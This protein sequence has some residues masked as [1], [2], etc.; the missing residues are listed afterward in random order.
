MFIDTD[1][2]CNLRNV[3]TLLNDLSPNKYLD[4]GLELKVKKTDIETFESDNPKNVKRVLTEIIS[5]W[6]RNDPKYSWE[7]LK[8]ALKNINENTLASAI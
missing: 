4:L 5:C 1:E 8:T 7:T 3:K 2:S 6:M